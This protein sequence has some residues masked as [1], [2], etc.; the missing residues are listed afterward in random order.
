MVALTKQRGYQPYNVLKWKKYSD[1]GYKTN[2][3]TW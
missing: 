1:K 3:E 2:R